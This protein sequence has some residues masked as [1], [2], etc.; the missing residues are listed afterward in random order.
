MIL[1]SGGNGSGKSVYAEKLAAS[2][3]APRFYI[4][5]MLAQNEENERRIEKHRRQREGLNFQTL[6]IP[7][8]VSKAEVSPDSLVLLEDASNLLANMVFVENGTKEDA[9]AEIMGLRSKC[10][11]LL[12]VTISGMQEDEYEGETAEYIRAVNWL[13]E[14]LFT[15]ADAAVK[16]HNGEPMV[17]GKKL[18]W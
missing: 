3:F 7:C 4:A 9:L 8:R 14:K 5:T 13:N 12:V 15:V 11:Q 1:I 16:M 18:E 6:E 17:S 2:S 10:S